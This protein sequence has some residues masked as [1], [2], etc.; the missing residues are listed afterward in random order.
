MKALGKEFDLAIGFAPVDTQTG[1]N[2]GKRVA[3]K[4]CQAVSFVLFKGAGTGT[5]IPVW[6]LQEH[7]ANT[8]GTSQNLAAITA[9][10]YKSAT[11][12][13]GTEAWTSSTQAASA[14]LSLT[15]EATKQGIYVVG[16]DGASLSDGFTHLSMSIADT[17]SAGAQLGCMLYVLHGLYVQRKPANL[18]A[19]L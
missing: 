12:L 13:A 4:G 18:A 10:H 8:G 11:T 19:T 3:M 9:W 15:G 6:T 16:V 5:D 2:T 17:G 7:N 1:A 14:T